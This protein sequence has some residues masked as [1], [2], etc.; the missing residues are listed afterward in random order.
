MKSVL[1]AI[2]VATLLALGA[3]SPAAKTGTHY[4]SIRNDARSNVYVT[5][6]GGVQGLSATIAPN[7]RVIMRGKPFRASVYARHDPTPL[8]GDHVFAGDGFLNTFEAID[9]RFLPSGDQVRVFE[10]GGVLRA[11]TIGN[12]AAPEAAQ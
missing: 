7:S 5:Y 8:I 6:S 2:A 3:C 4:L 11:Q 1:P 12:P 10:E 9:A